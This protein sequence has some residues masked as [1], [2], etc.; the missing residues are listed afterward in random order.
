[1]TP[2]RP[3]AIVLLLTILC[4]PAFGS[5]YTVLPGDTL[6]VQ[7]IAHSDLNSKQEVAPDGTASFPLIG[8]QS[9]QGKSLAELD[10]MLQSAFLP[11]VQNPQVVVSIKPAS[12]KANK[13]QDSIYVVIHDKANQSVQVKTVATTAEARAW[14]AAGTPVQPTTPTTNPQPGDIVQIETGREPDWWGENWYKVLSAAGI[15]MG[16]FNSIHH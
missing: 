15:V 11:Y 12:A 3:A 14:L 2:K 9:V 10:T 16:L 5:G 13:S 6:D 1:M 4:F 7:V 8:R